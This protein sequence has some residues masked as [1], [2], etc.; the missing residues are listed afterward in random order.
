ML[1]PH[2]GLV[3]GSTPSTHDPELDEQHARVAGVDVAC[4]D[5]LVLHSAI[6]RRQRKHMEADCRAHLHTSDG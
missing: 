3:E 5:D 4:S 2:V 1:G 6:L